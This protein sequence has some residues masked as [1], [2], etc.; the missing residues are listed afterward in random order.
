MKNAHFNCV[1]EMYENNSRLA[2][3]HIWYVYLCIRKMKRGER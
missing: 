1:C 3:M 2:L